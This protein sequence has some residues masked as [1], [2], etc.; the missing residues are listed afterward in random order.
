MKGI[1]ESAISASGLMAIR[2]ATMTATV[3][4]RRLF[5]SFGS[6]FMLPVQRDP[7]WLYP[8]RNSRSAFG[9]WKPR[10]P[11]A[12]RLQS[13]HA[14]MLVRA[15]S[16]NFRATVSPPSADETDARDEREAGG[17]LGDDNQVH[18]AYC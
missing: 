6:L 2:Q 12:M 14:R 11:R 3:T 10:I 7:S 16:L 8:V 1:C 4:L 17:G 9:P 18:A 15:S 13:L 5:W